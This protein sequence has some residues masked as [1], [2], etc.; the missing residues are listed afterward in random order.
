MHR[1]NM[2]R[3]KDVHV[4]PN[5]AI[6][7]E[8]QRMKIIANWVE[9][10]LVLTRSLYVLITSVAV[11]L[12]MPVMAALTQTHGNCIYWDVCW[13][14]AVH[15]CMSTAWFSL[16]LHAF[17]APSTMLI[18]KNMNMQL[19]PRIQLN[20]VSVIGHAIFFIFFVRRFVFHISF[21]M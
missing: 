3:M 12:A 20:T 13:P 6:E 11:G 21:W 10:W 15:C 5:P 14:V 19:N 8:E 9:N 4:D 2:E 17:G 18:N 1:I 7:C 16:F